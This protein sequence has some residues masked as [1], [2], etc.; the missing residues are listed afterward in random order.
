MKQL[1]LGIRLRDFAVFESFYAGPNAAAVAHLEKM[2]TGE[3]REPAVWLWGP[4]ATGKTHLLQ[5]VCA[6]A[7]ERGLESGFLPLD[8]AAE[9]SAELLDGWGDLRVVCLDNLQSVAGETEWE[10]S[11]FR[12]FNQL[13]ESAGTL[14]VAGDA[15][16]AA[17]R[18]KLKDLAS[19]L[20]WGSVF[21]LHPL[22]EPERIQA[23]QL[24]AV[25]RG[26]ELPD[27]TCWYL[28]RRHARDMN[29]LYNLLDTLD[30]ESMAEQRK[31]TVPFVKKV[32]GTDK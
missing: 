21:Q 12:L 23:L 25:Q 26:L 4:A 13:N 5:A 2:A 29:S 9:F 30:T 10:Q 1:P 27:E 3:H 15:S 24:R 8:Q 31:L 22:T 20:S 17:T 16:P 14:I 7:G 19:R 32:L 6:A 28:L 18:F 11:L